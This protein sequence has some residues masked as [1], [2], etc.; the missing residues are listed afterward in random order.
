MSQCST[1]APLLCD[2]DC[3][4]LLIFGL[5]VFLSFLLIEGESESRAA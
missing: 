4:R 3:M 5:L 1:V 2:R